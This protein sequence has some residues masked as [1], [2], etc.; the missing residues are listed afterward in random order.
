MNLLIVSVPLR[1]VLSKSFTMGLVCSSPIV[2]MNVESFG[3]EGSRGRLY[4]FEWSISLCGTR[5][6]E[7]LSEEVL[8]MI[9]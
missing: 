3:E 5:Y 2:A 1:L 8:L 4:E 6:D 7:G 9:A